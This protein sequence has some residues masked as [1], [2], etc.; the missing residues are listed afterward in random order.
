MKV[1]E[2]KND[3]EED[4][5]NRGGIG[6]ISILVSPMGQKIIQGLQTQRILLY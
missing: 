4:V 2:R 3:R 5:V 6:I 1:E